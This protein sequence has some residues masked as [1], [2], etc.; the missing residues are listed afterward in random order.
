MEYFPLLK[1][2]MNEQKQ[3]IESLLEKERKQVEE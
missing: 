2:E 3:K 1:K